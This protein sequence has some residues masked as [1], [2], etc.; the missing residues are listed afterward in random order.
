VTTTY[1]FAGEEVK[2]TE[3]IT[4]NSSE[5]TKQQETSESSKVEAKKRYTMAAV[6]PFLCDY[7]AQH[8]VY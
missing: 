7:Y 4:T 1:D 3:T 6:S 2:V 5:K 8:P